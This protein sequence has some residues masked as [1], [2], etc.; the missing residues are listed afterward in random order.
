MKDMT[1]I[2]TNDL[3]LLEYDFYTSNIACSV[4]HDVDVIALSPPVDPEGGWKIPQRPAFSAIAKI[5]K[6]SVVGG[7]FSEVRRW[8]AYYAVFPTERTAGYHQEPRPFYPL[9]EDIPDVPFDETWYD[10]NFSFI[11]HVNSVDLSACA[12]SL[13]ATISTLG[14]TPRSGGNTYGCEANLNRVIAWNEIKTER[15]IGYPF[16]KPIVASYLDLTSDYPDI[17][18]S[19]RIIQTHSN[20]GDLVVD[21]FAGWGSTGISAVQNDRD[22]MGCEAGSDK[23]PRIADDANDRVFS[24]YGNKLAFRKPSDMPKKSSSK[25]G[26][27]SLW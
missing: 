26:Q 11:A 6:Q 17:E 22:F 15:A 3:L 19:D 13:S 18:N 24:A 12:V 7:S 1:G 9:L 23:E 10:N 8:L 14:A 16:L 20:P 25:K 21:C 5:T 27:R 2:S 4:E